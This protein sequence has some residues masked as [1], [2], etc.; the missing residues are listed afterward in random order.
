[1]TYAV[2]G[3]PVSVDYFMMQRDNITQGSALFPAITFS[4]Y[5]V[6]TND[7]LLTFRTWRGAARTANK[8]EGQTVIQNWIV[9]DYSFY[10]SFLPPPSNPQEPAKPS[11]E[12]GS[13]QNPY[14]GCI[15]ANWFVNTPEAKAAFDD[16]WRRTQQSQKE[17]GGWYFYERKTNT[18]I[19]RGASEGEKSSMP[20]ESSEFDTQMTQF[21]QNGQSVILM[22]DLHTHPLGS[23]V[24]AGDMGNIN[25]LNKRMAS[26]AAPGGGHAPIGIVI[27][28]PGKITLYDSNG[29]LN[30]FSTRLHECL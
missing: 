3:I 11:H 30:K 7:G 24:S 18:L 15:T 5:S 21:R 17:N 19:G 16:L 23:G 10:A 14:P 1:M 8:T 25:N 20:N 13:K 26:I 4:H 22:F 9:T 6:K 2:D 28:G 12:A 29:P 27:H